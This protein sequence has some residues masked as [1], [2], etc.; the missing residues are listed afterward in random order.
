MSIP[1]LLEKMKRIQHYLFDFLEKDQDSQEH[2]ATLNSFLTKENIKDNQHELK[3]FLI[4]L[5]NIVNNHRY[6]VPYF[7]RVTQIL[8]QFK[9]QIL[10]YYSSPE[11]INIFIKNKRITLFLIEEKMILVDEYFVKKIIFSEFLK[12]LFY[13]HYFAPEIK[14]FMKESWFLKRNKDEQSFDNNL[15]DFLEKDLPSN[16]DPNRKKGENDSLICEIIRRDSINEFI[17]Y[18]KENE[19]PLDSYIENSIYETNRFFRQPY[20]HNLIE[21]ATFF[22]SIQI[23]EYILKNIK[24]KVSAFIWISAIHSQN[25]ELIHLLEKNNIEIEEIISRCLKESIKCHAFELTE[26][27]M[28]KLDVMEQCDD[29]FIIKALSAFNFSFLEN[30]HFDTNHFCYLCKYDHYLFV[31]I[32]LGDKGCDVNQMYISRY[33]IFK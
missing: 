12:Y 8:R 16:F 14:P 33:K 7:N 2:Y 22:G 1:I 24:T 5:C 6:T 23:T 18:I 20:K 9:P 32:L 25:M 29:K 3:A 15:I 11:I 26:Y 17:Q 10:Q 19:C 4:L 28:K 30:Y 27:L 13:G 21:Y 31:E